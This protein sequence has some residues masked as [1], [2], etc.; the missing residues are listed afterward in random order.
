MGH[1]KLIKGKNYENQTEK[2]CHLYD[3]E[4]FDDWNAER[5]I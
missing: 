3:W 4:L 2:F 5:Q 1:K